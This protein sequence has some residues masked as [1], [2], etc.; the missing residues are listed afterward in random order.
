[1]RWRSPAALNPKLLAVDLLLA[2]NQRPRAMFL[3]LLPGGMTVV[4]T[5]GPLDVLTV[6]ALAENT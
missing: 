6:H 3:C 1:M 4:L 5:I 2:E